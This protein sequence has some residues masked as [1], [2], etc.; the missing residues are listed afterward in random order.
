MRRA[1]AS[2]GEIKI[3][4]SL[5]MASAISPVYCIQILNPFDV[6]SVAFALLTAGE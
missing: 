5:L 2:P 3:T 1:V 4:L 6:H